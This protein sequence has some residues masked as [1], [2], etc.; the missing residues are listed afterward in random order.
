MQQSPRA[1]RHLLDLSANTRSFTLSKVM[2]VACSMLF[3]TVSPSFLKQRLRQ[4]S[5][6]TPEHW[7]S[8][9]HSFST[10]S[11]RITLSLLDYVY[12]S[13]RMLS[14]ETPRVRRRLATRR[15]G[16]RSK[17]SECWLRLA[18]M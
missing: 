2:T 5:A 9:R 17:R 6:Q 12:A 10:P 15:V 4:G 14:V 11:A 13:A 1:P 3:A 7:H 8:A 16:A 18:P